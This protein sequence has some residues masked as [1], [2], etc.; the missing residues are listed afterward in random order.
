MANV[1]VVSVIANI[2]VCRKPL[3]TIMK[4][5]V[6]L[7]SLFGGFLSRFQ[8]GTRTMPVYVDGPGSYQQPR[9]AIHVSWNDLVVQKCANVFFCRVY[10]LHL[11]KPRQHT[12][13]VL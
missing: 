3:L 8:H 10:T 4:V 9:L 2:A 13:F 12:V 6:L 1:A 7:L 5:Y 11:R